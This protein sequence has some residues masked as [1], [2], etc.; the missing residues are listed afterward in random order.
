MG[1]IHF[2]LNLGIISSFYLYG[3][4]ISLIKRFLDPMKCKMILITT[5]HFLK[6]SIFKRKHAESQTQGSEFLNIH[7]RINFVN[8]NPYL[9]RNE[10]LTS[11]TSAQE[12]TKPSKLGKYEHY[13]NSNRFY[14]NNDANNLTYLSNVKF[15]QYLNDG[16]N[17]N[18]PNNFQDY[19]QVKSMEN[20]SFQFKSNVTDHTNEITKVDKD[21]QNNQFCE[22]NKLPPC[23]TIINH[24]SNLQTPSVNKIYKK[25]KDYI[26]SYTIEN[27]AHSYSS[28]HIKRLKK[29]EEVYNIFDKYKPTLRY[30]SVSLIIHI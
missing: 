13:E 9:S 29:I 17:T 1:P 19:M 22:E 20:T 6:T 24:T 15:D 30:I 5:F 16:L 23:S 27:I 14:A 26:L 12:Y 10:T 4:A 2:I 21:H 28:G 8:N 3:W 11:F 18:M 7:D 25:L